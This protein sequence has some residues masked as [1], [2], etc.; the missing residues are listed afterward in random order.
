MGDCAYSSAGQ[1][2]LGTGSERFEP[3]K[4]LASL[5]LHPGF[6]G[7]YHAYGSLRLPLESAGPAKIAFNLCQ[8][9]QIVAISRI[10]DD[11]VT[12]GD[13]AEYIGSLIILPNTI[14]PAAIA[15]K[16]AYLVVA[17]EDARGDRHVES[18]KVIPRCCGSI[19]IQ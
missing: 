8:N 1:V 17:V 14:I 12:H 10:N 13:H 19:E 5:A 4:P 6:Q 16:E 7:G 15:D 2:E 3:L 11:L 9:D 18:V